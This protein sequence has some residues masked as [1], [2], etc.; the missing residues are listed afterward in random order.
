MLEANN[1]E[2]DDL[3]AR[4]ETARLTVTCSH[5]MGQGCNECDGEGFKVIGNKP[6]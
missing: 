2:T 5:C 1:K 4:N 3:T 6:H